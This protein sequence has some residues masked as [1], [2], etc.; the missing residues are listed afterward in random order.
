M[1]VGEILERGLRSRVRW[2]EGSGKEEK[3][4]RERERK[5]G[6]ERPRKEINRVEK[7]ERIEEKRRER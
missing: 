2:I 7:M 1:A 4:E 5:R 3:R 6:R